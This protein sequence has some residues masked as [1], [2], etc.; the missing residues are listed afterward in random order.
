MCGKEYNLCYSSRVVRSICDE[1]TSPGKMNEML[2][3]GSPIERTEAQLFVLHKLL[4]AGARF[5]KMEG[6]KYAEPPTIE[7]LHT[8]Y[9]IMHPRIIAEKIKETIILGS[10]VSVETKPKPQKGKGKSSPKLKLTPDR[11]MWWGLKMGLSRDETLD[12]PHGEL[13]SLINEYQIQNGMAD[14]KLT[15]SEEDPFPDWE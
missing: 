11:L 10:K 3:S 6:T 7:E 1:Y 15:N 5:A 12:V 13:L 8:L 9:P 14:V 4:D 2:E